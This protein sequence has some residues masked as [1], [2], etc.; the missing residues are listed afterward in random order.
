MAP[1]TS[2]YQSYRKN[3]VETAGPGALM[4]ML[5]NGAIKYI[6]QSKLALA[7]KDIPQANYYLGRVQDILSELMGSLDPGGD[8]LSRNLF[9]LYEYMYRLMIQANVKKSPELVEN[10]EEMLISLRDA[11][12]EALGEKQPVQ[13]AHES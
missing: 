6:R 7:E 4:L 5:Y 13:V 3:Q 2:P 11:W 8:A 9:S 1:L 12:Q 10:V